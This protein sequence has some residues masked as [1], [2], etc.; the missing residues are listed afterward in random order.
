MSSESDALMAE[1]DKLRQS[2]FNLHKLFTDKFEAVALNEA[3]A[4]ERDEALARLAYADSR[5]ASTEGAA[6][7]LLELLSDDLHEE[8]QA[9][10]AQ[11][12]GLARQL[13]DKDALLAEREKAASAAEAQLQAALAAH[14]ARLE[15]SALQLQDAEARSDSFRQNAD[16]AMAKAA[17]LE[18][19][20]KQAEETAAATAAARQEEHDTF[21]M[22]EIE[23]EEEP[24][25]LEPV[26]FDEWK[27]KGLDDKST[28]IM[29]LRLM[30]LDYRR[31]P[32]T[33]L[34]ETGEIRSLLQTVRQICVDRGLADSSAEPSP[35]Q[36][37]SFPEYLYA[38]FGNRSGVKSRASADGD[39]ARFLHRL[40]RL[41]GKHHELATFHSLLDACE[42]DEVSYYVHS[43]M[44]LLGL[45]RSS[46]LSIEVDMN[47]A[48]KACN[49]LIMRHAKDEHACKVRTEMTKSLLSSK[50]ILTAS[51]AVDSAALL[52]GLLAVY[53]EEKLQLR[54]MLEV[55][56]KAG[57]NLRDY[58]AI[59][60]VRAMLHS[61][62][63]NA[64]D[65][66]VLDIYQRC[67]IADKSR[68]PSSGSDTNAETTEP[69]RIV[70]F[71]ML[72]VVLERH[73]FLAKRQRIGMKYQPDLLHDS[74]AV[75]S[76]ATDALASWLTAEPYVRAMVKKTEG[77]EF[78]CERLWS[79]HAKHLMQGIETTTHMRI[80]N[81]G[82]E[83]LF[84]LKRLLTSAYC[85]QSLRNDL[86][87][88]PA[89]AS[90]AAEELRLMASVVKER[91]L[92]ADAAQVAPRTSGASKA[93]SKAAAAVGTP[94]ASS[95]IACKQRE[96]STRARARPVTPSLAA[97]KPSIAC[98]APRPQSAM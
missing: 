83:A 35:A 49:I 5:L 80:R 93:V 19:L 10:G 6:Q 69:A 20:L 76:C 97:T 37:L 44:V 73:G 33:S 61:V 63:P 26:D 51:G 77:S 25:R 65:Y 15:Q 78:E 90:A 56:H 31:P 38:W 66:E 54:A 43:R 67:N 11:L 84:Q 23:K 79:Q 12:S 71:N 48:S 40:D 13:A 21:D 7:E 85:A 86:C 27:I 41:K 14:Q 30:L 74:P 17:K 70:P 2:L 82:P 47:S 24:H 92:L 1:N 4:Q 72:W 8:L 45:N 59:H 46:Q 34:L 58:P 42:V 18:E 81:N 16:A 88:P 28:G 75:K 89:N 57:A 36:W 32:A 87:F 3:A 50:S 96:V 62:D 52:A 29:R 68:A 39:C 53:K 60:K 55:L 94:K 9:L 64:S 95:G 22:I 98:A 91:D